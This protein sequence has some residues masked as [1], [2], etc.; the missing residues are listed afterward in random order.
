M[1]GTL[2][3]MPLSR[4]LKACGVILFRRQPEPR[5]LLM[6]HRDRW[7]LP[8]G[9][10]EAGETE[11][12]CALRELQEETGIDP[13]RVRLDRDFR[14][15]CQYV[16]PAS[17]QH[18]EP[19][20]KTLVV[21]LGWLDGDDDTVQ[22][23]EHAGYQWRAWRPPHAIQLQT[24]DPLLAAVD[25]FWRDSGP[26]GIKCDGHELVGQ[27]RRPGPLVGEL[28]HASCVELWRRV[29]SR[30]VK[31]GFIIEYRDLEPPRTGIFD[32]L[33]IVIDPD[34]D[35]E[36]QCFVLLHLFGHSVQWVAP[37]LHGQLDALQHAGEKEPFMRA[38]HDYEFQAAQFGLQLLNEA[39]L[40]HLAQWFSDFVA[41]DW[42]Y[43]ERSYLEDKIPPWHECTVRDSPLVSALPIP[44]L[45]HRQVEVRFA[46]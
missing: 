19:A 26:V 44:A 29:T 13:S 2:P 35:F 12:A 17:K 36:M 10:L 32:G 22:V 11:Q 1:T 4:E 38:L 25:R 20:R 27:R 8:K 24:I 42:R 31:Y 5:F 3:H 14:F 7:D 39:G 21:F 15:T 46:F 16:V 43:V 23:T 33:R 34:V 37:S 41:T 6:Q 30:V 18:G 40:Q 9:H 45:E 28:P